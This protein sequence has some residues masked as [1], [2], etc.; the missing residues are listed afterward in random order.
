MRA[1]VAIQFAFQPRFRG[2]SS[3]EQTRFWFA[4][5]RKEANVANPRNTETLASLRQALDGQ[6][7]FFVVNYQGLPAN[8][9]VK[10]RKELRGVGATMVVAKNT[11]MHKAVSERGFEMR[12]LF[13]GPSALVLV[14]EDAVTPI[15]TLS[16]FSKKNDKG[17]PSAKGGVL[18][19]EQLD[20]KKL[21]MISS[22]PSKQE[23][24][25]QVV[26]VLSSKLQEFVGIL[27]AKVEK[28]GGGNSSNTES[29]APAEPAPVEA[30]PVEAT[31]AE[32]APA[33]SSEAAPET[34][35][36]ES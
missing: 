12:D 3:S 32:A 11:L 22:L 31:P 7:S 10:L 5:S 35:A 1:W 14:G 17:I 19:G 29:A 6:S 34:P 26:G 2:Q 15:K 16:E 13:H 33:T 36:S 4:F 25:G 9:V 21:D 30:T 27:E 28:D 24:R 8:D 18:D 20:A 23:L